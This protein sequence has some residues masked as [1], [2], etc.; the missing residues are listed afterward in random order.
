MN[1]V[2]DAGSL[3]VQRKH[4]SAKTDQRDAELLVRHL[5]R[6][7]AGERNVWRERQRLRI[8]ALVR[9][10]LIAMGRWVAFDELAVGIL[11]ATGINQSLNQARKVR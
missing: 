2:V 11:P 8:V 9:K 7:Q 10:I 1:L 5:L 4:R 6:W 3:R